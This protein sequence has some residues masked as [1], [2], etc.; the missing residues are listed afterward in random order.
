ML[1]LQPQPWKPVDSLYWAKVLAWSLS[2]NWD[3]ELL[4]ARMAAKLGADRAT[5]LEPLY[6]ADNP[7]IISGTGLSG[8]AE[9]PP[10]GWRSE[11]LRDA[12]RLVED[13][14]RDSSNTAQHTAPTSGLSQPTGNSNQWVVAGSRSDTGK[15]LLANDTHLPLQMPSF[16]YH[17]HLCGGRYNVIGVSFPALPGVIIGHNDRCAWG[18]TTAWQDAQDLYVV[19]LNPE[20]PRQ[21]EYQGEWLDAR[22]ANEEIQVKGRGEP[23]VERVVITRHGPL[24]NGLVGEE[25]PLA[26]RW[27]AMEPGH[28][29][30]AVLRYNRARNW[31]DFR[32]ALGDWSTPAHN[33][34]Y[35][36]VEGNIGYLQAGWM[37]VR[38]KGYGM[39]PVPGWTGEYEWQSYLS[40]D[41]L[42][43][44]YNPE[45]DWLAT[46][47]NQVAE[48]DYPHFLSVDLEDPIRARRV[49]DLITSKKGLTARD[50]ARFQRDTYSAQAK[51]FVHHM[52]SLEPMDDQERRA[53]SYL[54]NWDH[55]MAQ[56]SVAA[57]IYQ[58]CRLRA[59][60]L[61]FGGH[62]GELTNSYVGLSIRPLSG[63]NPYHWRSFIRL[64]DLLDS[65]KSEGD[66]FWLGDPAGGGQRSQ[67]TLLR[68]AL[69]EALNLLQK[70]LGRDMARWTWGRLNKIHFAHPLGSVKPLH[71]LFNRGPYP[72][73]GG[74]DTL[75]RAAGQ[76]KFPFE[77]VEVVD[78]LRF[79]ADLS[80][81][82]KCRIATPGG[83]SGHVASRHY[84][85]LISLWQQGHYLPMFFERTSVERHGKRRL[86]LIPED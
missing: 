12:L 5:D 43:Q 16:Y 65:P 3:G 30:R 72:I 77:P 64:L 79:I 56:S 14:F 9:L 37:P 66:E 51:R 29:L 21:Y 38:A 74:H 76:P 6:P 2:G 45:N 53:L 10:N 19:K 81:W 11:A 23:V 8:D 55:R 15:P 25:I 62:L 35:A 75:L 86:R 20:D 85:D 34:I 82:E 83:Q 68:Q 32:L 69:R 18:L 57:S 36:D 44:A 63:T 84:T 27:V 40:L 41:E 67:Q 58:V 13:L 22:V 50:F 33:F 71:L 42:P 59:L 54:R 73:G 28:S 48:A 24:I 80:D 46:A 49:V 61:F 60:H 39:V 47:N 7:S 17:V 70:E 4:R 78:A 1:R 52:L 26:L 31:E